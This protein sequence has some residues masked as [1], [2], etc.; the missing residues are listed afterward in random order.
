MTKKFIRKST[1]ENTERITSGRI[2]PEEDLEMSIKALRVYP[3]E[4]AIIESM[5]SNLRKIVKNKNEKK[6]KE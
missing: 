3:I 2:T 5:L 6:S 4:P 1:E